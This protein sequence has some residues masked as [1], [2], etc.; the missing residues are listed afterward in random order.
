MQA[1]ALTTITWEYDTF[2]DL[3][4][5][6]LNGKN[7]W[8]KG[9]GVPGPVVFPSGPWGNYLKV[10]GI[11]DEN[12]VEKS[13]ATQSRGI[14]TFDFNWRPNKNVTA[15][16]IVDIELGDKLHF[17]TG[18]GVIVS[19]HSTDRRTVIPPARA[20]LDTWYSIHCVFALPDGPVNI[21]VNG[22]PVVTGY[23]FDDSRPLDYLAI[24]GVEAPGAITVDNLV[25]Q[26]VL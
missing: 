26:T 2:D 22:A 24:V 13:F 12:R 19:N 10:T 8:I 25:G 6:P 7:G 16:T 14:A 17:Q 4:V 21:Y 20:N 3:P 18:L 23:P 9:E 5:G 1:S 11:P 15:N